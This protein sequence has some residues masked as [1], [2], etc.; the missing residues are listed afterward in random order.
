MRTH[1]FIR[2]IFILPFLSITQSDMK[3]TF[4]SSFMQTYLIVSIEMWIVTNAYKKIKT[5]FPHHTA[6]LQ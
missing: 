1:N 2:K 3:I 6:D 5:C 4:L